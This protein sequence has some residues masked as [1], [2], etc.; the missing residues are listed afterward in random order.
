MSVKVRQ[1]KGHLYLD[2]YNKGQRRW[3]ALHLSVPKD[4]AQKREVLRTAES[5]RCKREQQ[6]VMKNYQLL[7]PIK[8]CQSLASYIEPIAKDYSAVSHVVKM[9]N[10]LKKFNSVI[11]LQ[12]VDVTFI[13]GF[14]SFLVT[15]E[16]LGANTCRHYIKA[17][18]YILRRAVLDRLIN[19]NPADFVAPI[20]VPE[21]DMPYLT[22]E[23]IQKLFDTPIS[24]AQLAK[25]SK[26]AFLLSCFTG[27]RLG[28]LRTLTWGDIKPGEEPEI[29]KQINKT[30]SRLT[31]PLVPKALELLGKGTA[32]HKDELIFPALAKTKSE[33]RPIDRWRK[34][35]GLEKKFGWHAAR[36]S[37]AMMVL[38]T[39]NDIFIVSKLLGH[40]SINITTRYLHFANQ[41]ARSIFD[42][43]PSLKDEKTEQ[44]N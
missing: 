12:D 2:I 5:V 4:P 16:H 26:R 6:L 25:E 32:H 42:A 40:S 29:S 39:T 3:E 33:Y 22:I 1:K 17:L 10:H 35:A 13:E 41:Q 44:G 36:H 19:E 20:K 14:K 15:Q 43:L 30:G 31:L 18:K 34:A 27:L 21:P 28:D 9:L 23:E 24:G 37:F 38:D 8:A 7:D 11:S